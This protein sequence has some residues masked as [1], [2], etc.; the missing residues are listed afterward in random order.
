VK[1]IFRPIR[2]GY[3]FVK[4]VSQDC[5]HIKIVS[6]KKA[7]VQLFPKETGCEWKKDETPPLTALKKV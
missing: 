6:E 1:R 7:V 2:I 5:N 3:L 4:S